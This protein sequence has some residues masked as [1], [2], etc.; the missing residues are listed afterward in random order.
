MTA[1]TR[2]F[3]AYV[4][5]LLS[6]AHAATGI[7]LTAGEVSRQ[8]HECEGLGPAACTVTVEPFGE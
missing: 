4:A 5:I 6:F 3:L 1:E 2:T 7:A 8:M